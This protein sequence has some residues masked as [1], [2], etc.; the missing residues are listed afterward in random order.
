MNCDSVLTLISQYGVNWQ[1]M[2]TVLGGPY[3][4]LENC[5]IACSGSPT[6]T[7]TGSPTTSTTTTEGPLGIQPPLFS[8]NDVFNINDFAVTVAVEYSNDNGGTWEQHGNY[9]L[10][11]NQDAQGAFG[12]GPI[13]RGRCTPQGGGSELS[14][15]SWQYS[16]PNP[17]NIQPPLFSSNDVLNP[18][19]FPVVVAV[20]YS[21]DSG[22]TWIQHGNYSLSA[23]QNAQGAFGAGPI[24][25]GRCASQGSGIS[26]SAISS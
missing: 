11:A 21:N 18:N 1:S 26:V 20:E 14:A 2:V 24:Y 4:S 10:S 7:T 23:N 5:Q 13:Y 22:A 15:W 12:A 25:R 3:D 17:D 19:D 8:S 6:T 9:N 16:Y